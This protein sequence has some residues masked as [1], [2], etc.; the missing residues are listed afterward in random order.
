MTKK[1]QS[2]KDVYELQLTAG[3]IVSRAEEAESALLA[4]NAARAVEAL[5]GA[6][7]SVDMLL[8]RYRVAMQALK[9]AHDDEAANGSQSPCPEK[10]R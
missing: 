4:G 1:E 8:V 5:A 7:V 2:R 10:T 3:V 9:E 6:A